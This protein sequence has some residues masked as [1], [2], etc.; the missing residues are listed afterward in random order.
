MEN[1]KYVT[2]KEAELL[3]RKSI[4]TLRKAI[5]VYK[6]RTQRSSGNKILIL[7]DD[8]V[9]R[10]QPNNNHEVN[11]NHNQNSSHLD[12]LR[13]VID[14]LS[15]Q[16]DVKDKQIEESN[17]RLSEAHIM[18][19]DTQKDKKQLETKIL[20]LSGV[21]IEDGDGDTVNKKKQKKGLWSKLFRKD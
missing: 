16:L 11:H 5:K 19:N 2:L 4:H 6:F 1:S 10:Y 21:T 9:S 3:T 17:K 7:Y 18:L 8:L 12:S 13:A 14:Q 20:L 15:K